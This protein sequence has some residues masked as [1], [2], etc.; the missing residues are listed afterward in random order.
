LRTICPGWPQ[1][2]IR[3]MS[4]SQVPRI[5]GVSYLCG[6]QLHAVIRKL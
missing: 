4:A 6:V 5:T 2:S 3:P 1:T